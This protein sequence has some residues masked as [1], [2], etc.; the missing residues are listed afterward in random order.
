M[1]MIHKIGDTM[2]HNERLYTCS[3]ADSQMAVFTSIIR[4]HL[5]YSYTRGK[6]LHFKNNNDESNYENKVIKIEELY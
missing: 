5:P 3:F 4:G 2:T 1:Q 6:D